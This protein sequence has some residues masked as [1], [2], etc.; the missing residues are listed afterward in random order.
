MNRS[1]SRHLTI[2]LYLNAALLLA[3]VLVLLGRDGSV[4]IT[5]SAM[6]QSTGFAGGGGLYLMPAQFGERR[7]GCYIMD[8]D[9]QTV[10][11]YEFSGN[12]LR[13]LAARSFVHD[14]QL[15]NYNTEPPPAEVRS[16]VQIERDAEPGQTPGVAPE[17]PGG[18]SPG[19]SPSVNPG[20]STP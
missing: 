13:L 4:S 20:G 18:T 7:F 1:G 9:A 17:Q 12:R 6:A 10:S 15:K 16:L 11:A 5:P 14:R 8:T 3:I 2:A 19:T